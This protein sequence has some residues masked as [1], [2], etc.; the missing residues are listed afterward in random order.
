MGIAYAEGVYF[1][2]NAYDEGAD[3]GSAFGEDFA[4]VEDVAL[5]VELYAYALLIC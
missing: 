2:G 3:E 4:V 5:D 1:V